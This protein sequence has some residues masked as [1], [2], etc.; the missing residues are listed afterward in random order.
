MDP[1]SVSFTPRDDIWRIHSEMLRVQQTQAEHADRLARLERRQ[2]ED[3]RVKSVWGTSSPFPSV[4]GGTPQQVPLQQPTADAFSG[5]D[6]Q[7]NNLL[8]SLH[9]DA[10]EEPRR[11]GT[12]SRANS[13]RFDETANQGHWSHASRSS[14]DLIPRAGSSL[15]GHLM[16]ERSYSHKS[17]GRQSSAAASVHSVTSGRANSLGLESTFP[18]GTP[19]LEVPRLAPGLFILG[20]VPAIIRCWLNRNFK[21]DSL[22]YAAV[23]TGSY[24]SCLDLALITK[25]GFESEIRQIEDGNR[26]IKLEL[27]LPEAIPYPASSRSG[28]PTPQLPSLTV[29]FTVITTLSSEAD[30]KA[31]KVFLGSDLLRAHNADILLSSNTLTLFDDDR[32]KLSVPLVR[33]EDD[34]A[35]KTLQV[36]SSPWI[37]PSEEVDY[38]TSQEAPPTSRPGALE[39]PQPQSLEALK[40]TSV[41][42]TRAGSDSDRNVTLPSSDDGTASV[43]EHRS[44][45]RPAWGSSSRNDSKESA[46]EGEPSAPTFPRSGSS[47]AIWNNWRRPTDRSESM[48]W[49]SASKAP[50]SD[51]YQ[52]RDTGIK[53]LKPIRT[54]SRTPSSAAQGPASALTPTTQ[55]R[56]FD[57]GRRRVTSVSSA[58]TVGVEPHQQPPQPK[59]TISTDLSKLSGSAKDGGKPRSA[60]PVGGASAFSWLKN[61]QK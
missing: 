29:D 54:S 2:D 49:A 18:V 52:R 60:N 13:V 33:P 26:K 27:Y 21:H 9:L 50:S 17:D 55:S 24:T 6:D 44:V 45:E 36:S 47:P 7:S 34:R 12:T 57:E 61:G 40:A 11:L 28:S 20:S 51:T 37:K 39:K 23:C 48:D 10:D 32:S 16:T 43:S 35:F 46:T 25:L 4:L 42:P 3:A 22:L 5:F 38:Q 59:R 8:S 53:V 1:Q 15:G 30:D 19:A 41:S 58:S 56:F 31:I 14:M